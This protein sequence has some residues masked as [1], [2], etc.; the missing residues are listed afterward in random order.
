MTYF[1][2]YLRASL[3]EL[4]CVRGRVEIVKEVAGAYASEK[5]FASTL[6]QMKAIKGFKWKHPMI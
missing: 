6:S 5:A 2:G 4:E 1:E 3:A